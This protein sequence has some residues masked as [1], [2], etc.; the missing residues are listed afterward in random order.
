M[1]SPVSIPESV[2]LAVHALVRMAA[3]R[4]S[5]LKLGDL[6]V[7]PGSMDHLSKVMQKLVAAGMV[8]S[9]RGRSG[10]FLLAVDPS[11]IRLMDV[12]I[13]LEGTFQSA[14]CPFAGRGCSMRECVFGTVA[15]DAAHLIGDYFSRTTV[16]DLAG[17][18]MGK[19]N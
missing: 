3:E 2:S 1:P 19:G 9:R 14:V 18:F 13:A 6:M 7:R 17:L 15:S 4:D 8:S 10:G 5:V 16:A 11:D 12:W